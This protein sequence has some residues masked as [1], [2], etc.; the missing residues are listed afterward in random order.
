[1]EIPLKALSQKALFKNHPWLKS[2]N[3][4]LGVVCGDD[5]DALLSTA[6]FLKHHPEATF[7]GMYT[8][9]RHLLVSRA[10]V[11]GEKPLVWM[12]LDISWP[13]MASL[14]HHILRPRVKDP[15]PIR[16]P[17]LN[18]NDLRGVTQAQFQKKYPLGTAHFLVWLYR[19][20]IP[21]GSKLES[22][23][24]LCDSAFINGQSHRYRENVSTWLGSMP[25]PDMLATLERLDSELFEIQL[26]PV[27][28]EIKQLGLKSGR[29]QARSAH[30][31]LSA[32]P[33]H[34]SPFQVG[35]F[36]D[37]CR[38]LSG[39]TGLP[40]LLE[41]REMGDVWM[42]E[43]V[44]RRESVGTLLGKSSLNAF[45]KKEKVFSFALPGMGEMNY[46]TKIAWPK[47]RRMKT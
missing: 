18:L 9:F 46:T 26:E 16:L 8:G 4:P 30:R 7:S 38:W 28:G 37:F 19:E 10:C 24:W 45:L 13:G 33:F 47:M 36:Q 40:N 17:G 42:G 14:G 43:G 1:M 23:L 15:S 2:G 32:Y 35:L 29:T 3:K 31:A 44:R 11:Q 25:H 21:Q 20:P 12:D 34:L 6:L 39:A 22:L 5:L 27:I 41:R